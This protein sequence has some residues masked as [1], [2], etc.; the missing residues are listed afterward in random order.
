MSLRRSDVGLA[1]K[2]AAVLDTIRR[3]CGGTVPGDVIS[4]LK[5]LPAMLQASGVAVTMAFLYSKAGTQRSL[6]R[7]YAKIRDALLAELA[8]EWDWDVAERVDALEFFQRVSDPLQVD[9]AALSRA[10]VR[11]QS[12]AMWLRRLAEAVEHG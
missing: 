6:E 12:F 7:A 1:G 3:D 8:E 4:Q 10:S 11:L 2:A 5:G 9:P